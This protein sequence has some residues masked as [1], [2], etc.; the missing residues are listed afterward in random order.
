[1]L[2]KLD[3]RRG[4]DDA[5]PQRGYSKSTLSSSASDTS[6]TSR[7]ALEHQQPRLKP[8]SLPINTRTSGLA[9]SPLSR[10]AATDSPSSSAISPGN[11]YSRFGHG[12]YDYRSPSDTADSD[13]S[14][15]Q[16]VREHIR[17]SASASAISICDDTFSIT[18]R[19]RE[20]YEQKLSP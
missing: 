2:Q 10:W 6:P 14:P 16:Y 7:I 4:T 9:E 1:M 18:S 3:F 11:P 13:R 5:A 19:S 15:H 17:G 12:P 8:L 20:S